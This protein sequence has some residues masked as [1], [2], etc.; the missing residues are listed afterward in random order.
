MYPALFLYHLITKDAGLSYPSYFPE[1]LI[2]EVRESHRHLRYPQ[3]Q[4][5][6]FV[7][8]VRHFELQRAWVGENVLLLWQA[9]HKIHLDGQLPDDWSDSAFFKPEVVDLMLDHYRRITEKGHAGVDLDAFGRY[10][11]AALRE[12][13][14]RQDWVFTPDG[15][16]ERQK[17]ASDSGADIDI[18]TVKEAD[19]GEDIT[20]KPVSTN[21][22]LIH[23]TG[24]SQGGI[25]HRRTRIIEVLRSLGHMHPVEDAQFAV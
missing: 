10:F 21:I 8:L 6:E 13:Q 2:T 15:D 1:Q 17:G 25:D 16:I 23:T 22:A 7:R 14:F 3:T 19:Q 18:P 9:A 4:S 5:Y 24:I 20:S 12:Y 11:K